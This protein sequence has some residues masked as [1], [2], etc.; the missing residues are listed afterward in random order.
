ML[1]INTIELTSGALTKLIFT[2]FAMKVCGALM[3]WMLCACS[4]SAPV[5]LGFLGGLSGRVSDFGEAGRNGTLLAVEDANAVG[6]INGHLIELVI[7]DDEQN[8]E[9]AVA[10][11]KKMLAAKVAA[12]IGPMTSAMGEAMLPIATQAETVVVSPTISA[13]TL[14]A[15][16]DMLFAVSPSVSQSATLSATYE[17]ARGARRVAIV[18][19]LSNRAYTVDWVNNFGKGF[20]AMGGSVVAEA[21]FVSGDDASYS[22]AVKKLSGARPD[23]LSYVANAVDTVRLIQV[24]RNLGMTQSISASPW[25]ATERLLEVGGRTVEG[26]TT[27]QYFNRHDSSA[28]YLK[29]AT[30]FRKRFKQ[31]PD[32]VSVAAYDATTAV[33][34]AMRQANGR[35]LKRALLENGSFQGLQEPWTFGPDGS[36]QR[37]IHMT[38][39]RDGR[40]SSTP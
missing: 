33:I 26:V 29:F 34:S 7:G 19:D 11:T 22:Q 10:A 16:D 27:P 3:L 35:P 36:A 40:Y 2:N 39:V 1:T 13:T 30:A 12:I 25:A 6:G 4:P 31:E 9:R 15:K 37:Q 20:A 38:V 24:S 14:L 17:Y 8:A 28:P 32:F 18:Y 21:S 5:K 23:L